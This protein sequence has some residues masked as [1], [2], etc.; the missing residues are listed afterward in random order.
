[1][2]FDNYDD[3]SRIKERLINEYLPAKFYHRHSDIELFV[4]ITITQIL[5]YKALLTDELSKYIQENY[6][7]NYNYYE[8]IKEE[9][10]KVL[11][12]IF[13]QKNKITTDETK[14]KDSILSYDFPEFEI[15]FIAKLFVDGMER[16][17]ECC[18]KLLFNSTNINQYI[19]MRFKYKDLT[20]DS[21]ILLELYSMQLP[22]DKNLLATTKIYLFDNNL[23]LGQGRHIFKLN[24][25]QL[26]SN[27]ESQNNEN[28][29]SNK[30]IE[31]IEREDQL[32][33]IGKEIDSLINSFYGSEFS[34]SLDY[35]GKL[36]DEEKEKA[37]IKQVNKFESIQNNYYFNRDLQKPLVKTSSMQQYD[38]KLEELLRKTENAY[39]VIKFPSFKN[40]VIYEEA[41]S[42]NY[43]KVFKS[44]YRFDFRDDEDLKKPYF[45]YTTWVFDPFINKSKKDY[46]STENPVENKFSILTRSNDDDLIARDIRLNP[47][48][49]SQINEVLNMPDFI[50]LESKNITLF[51]SHRYELLKKNTPYAL[52]K[53]MNSVKW[54][55]PK[56]ENEFIKNILYPWKTVEI[57]DI[58]YM[59]SR[60]FSVNK[61]YPN[62]N[63]VLEHFDGMKKIREYA[64]SKLSQLKNEELNF[65]LLQLVQAIRY[66]DISTKNVDSPL[67]EFLISS[68]CKDTILS[69][70][71]F[72]FIECES[73]T[74]DQGPKTSEQEKEITEIFGKIR[75]KFFEYITKYPE[76]LKIINNE[77]SFKEELVAISNKLSQVSKVENKKK[78]LYNLIENEKKNSFQETEYYLPIDPRL[79]IK[80]TITEGCTVFKSAKCPVKYTFKVTED[81]KKY[82]NHADKDHM[83]IMFKYGDD[84]RQDQLILQMISYMD[85]LLKNMHLDYEF[86][87]YKTLATS[88]SDGFVE[89]VPNSKT[90]F[91]IKKLYNNQIRAYYEE[92]SG[93]DEKIL[94]KKLDSYINSCAGYC[95][96]TYILGIGDRHLENLMIDNNGRLF[97][98]DFGYILGKDPKPM[99]PPIKLCKEMVECMGGKGSKRYEEFQQKCVNAYWVLRDNARVIV[100]MFYLMIDSG[101]PELNNIDNLKKLHEKFVP[102]KNKQE[103]SNYILD[104]LR[105][106]VDAMMPVFMEKLHAW[107]IYWK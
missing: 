26:E 49:R 13:S 28:I 33:D 56:S 66:E 76:I 39:V 92:I 97:H 91:D 106:S 98:I 100:N 70:S 81:T 43:K 9:K 10:E 24:K 60:K 5:N 12:L 8:D 46:I 20:I 72:W 42:K 16:K 52:T 69:S 103:A 82:N 89:F 96:V 73:D 30:K 94:N 37:E 107:A 38:L 22:S 93:K 105:E 47:Y 40:T 44:S 48:S 1:M 53:I 67:V 65:I 77:L 18:T 90:I 74:S 86:T 41:I 55:E 88:K 15:Y 2:S 21:Y 58:L 35:Y 80:G 31:N 23:N 59:L 101:I 102:Q 45:K 64:I 36:N 50:E 27:K 14:Y 68:C 75:D 84:L 4:N 85:S 54:G 87:T 57:C 7:K 51:W 79:K 63:G 99:P 29:D 19:S 78:E 11:K 61:L 25:V 62:T 34:K 3:L 6:G 71:F 104:N 17:P 95:V 32:D 83:R